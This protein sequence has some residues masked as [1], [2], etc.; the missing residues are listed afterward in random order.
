MTRYIDLECGGVIIIPSSE[1]C[2]YCDAHPKDVDSDE[3]DARG[4]P[5][6]TC[7]EC[8]CDWAATS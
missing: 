2:P 3:Y 5:I 8:G 4:R 6:Y 7:S 1:R